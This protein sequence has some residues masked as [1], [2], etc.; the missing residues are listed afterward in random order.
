MYYFCSFMRYDIDYDIAYD[1]PSVSSYF[2]EKLYTKEELEEECVDIA[3][4]IYTDLSRYDE[5][6]NKNSSYAKRLFDDFRIYVTV[7][8]ISGYED[9][10]SIQLSIDATSKLYNIAIKEKCFEFI[11]EAINKK[12]EIRK[13]K[14]SE[15]YKSYLELKSKYN[16]VD[17]LN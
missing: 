13:I 8:P 9:K 10:E 2:H 12:E 1:Q 3:S 6:C 17:D 14:E 5:N 15:E 7:V 11:N 4:H 16:S